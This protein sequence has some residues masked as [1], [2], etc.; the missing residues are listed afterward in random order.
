[1]VTTCYQSDSFKIFKNLKL[2]FNV[3]QSG[4][5]WTLWALQM[6]IASVI[7]WINNLIKDARE[8]N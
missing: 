8:S 6:I 3:I 1:M 2:I 4:E 5:C 7:K